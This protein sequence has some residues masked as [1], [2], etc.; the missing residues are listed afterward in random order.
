L[1]NKFY[2]NIY[3]IYNSAI[4]NEEP[5]VVIIHMVC[6]DFIPEILRRIMRQ[7]YKNI[8]YVICSDSSKTEE[9]QKEDAFAKK[10]NLYI[11]RRPSEHR[12]QFGVRAGN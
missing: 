5:K 6:N 7:K 12:K 10:H 9:I 3:Q 4:I 8:E 11:S 1:K 2:K